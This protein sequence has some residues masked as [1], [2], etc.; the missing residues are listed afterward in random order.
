MMKSWIGPD[1]KQR[2]SASVVVHARIVPGLSQTSYEAAI[3]A[4]A[5]EL[6]IPSIGL[7]SP[8]PT[9]LLLCSLATALLSFGLR[10]LE[11]VVS[12]LTSPEK[13]LSRVGAFHELVPQIAPV[14]D[15]MVSPL[16]SHRRQGLP[17]RSS[18]RRLALMLPVLALGPS[19][20]AGTGLLGLV[21]LSWERSMVPSGLGSVS[22]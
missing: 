2:Q 18:A 1:D 12:L 7:A 8:F 21:P 9:P 16:R 6:S 17:V 15:L 11:P 4:G 19:R 14:N 3:G 10:S 13:P 22:V 5:G 20:W